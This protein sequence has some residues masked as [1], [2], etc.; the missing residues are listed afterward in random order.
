MRMSQWMLAIGIVVGIGCLRVT[1]RTALVMK[2]YAVGERSVRLHAR[3]NEIAWLQ[4][5]VARMSSPVRLA[6]VAEERRMDLVAWS[7]LLPPPTMVS[8]VP[9]QVDDTPNE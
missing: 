9:E 7:R 8:M 3:D 2:S 6:Q 1:Q 4:T 5:R